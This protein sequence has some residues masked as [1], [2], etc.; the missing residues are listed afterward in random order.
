MRRIVA[1]AVLA[2]AAVAVAVAAPTIDVRARTRLMVVTV[3]RTG[4]GAWVRGGLIDAGSGEGVA[5]R[6]VT[7]T[8]DGQPH[9]ATTG[10]SGRFDVHV[11]APDVRVTVGARFAGDDIYGDSSFEPRPYDAAR[12][13]L[14]LEVR[15]AEA[16]DATAASTE[17]AITT[18][19]ED[20]PESVRVTLR[21]GDAAGPGT[22]RDVGEVQTDESGLARFEIAREKLGRPG[23]KRVLARFAGSESL[24]PAEAEAAFV[25]YTATQ[26][27]DLEVPEGTVR[28]ERS[29]TLAGK[30]LDAEG[31]PVSG[32]IV[33]LER[34][35]QRL[36]DAITDG[37]GRFSMRQPAADLGS[38]PQSV[39]LEHRSTVPWRRGTL[40][41]PISL[42]IAPP[43]PV[44]WWVSFAAF[45]VTALAALAYVLARTQPWRPLLARWRARRRRPESAPDAPLTAEEEAPAP[46]LKL[47]RP[48]LMSGL[49]RAADHGLSGRVRDLVRGVPVGGARLVLTLGEQR[50]ELAADAGGHFEIELTAGTW[51]IEVT[52]FGYVTEVVTAPVPHKGEL[53][54]ARIDLL[55][56]RERVFALYREVA[57][58]LLPRAELWGVWTP[59]EILDHMRKRRPAGALGALTDLVEHAYFAERV[60]DETVIEET[61]AA[62]S[63]AHAELR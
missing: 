5:G 26:L 30:L 58:P 51:R 10:A 59:R 7:V 22:L 46:G 21:A 34:D 32:A 18:A 41:S 35:G 54:G 14:V 4:T 13:S 19:S 50:L 37:K 31:K 55:P 15:V 57:A 24:N 27:T 16:V 44:P 63:A 45:G 9:Q 29:F 39:V 23:E 47:A 49:R 20:G 48:G 33:S 38:G 2:T 12:A 42:E 56:V 62:V 28:Y 36:R 3:A 11:D 17:M 43:R 61:R 8:V 53:R 52:A 60:P 6:V 1:A 40:S 25:L